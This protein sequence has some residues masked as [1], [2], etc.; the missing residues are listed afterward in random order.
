MGLTPVPPHKQGQAIS[1]TEQRLR[2]VRAAM[3]GEERFELSRVDL[4]RPGPHYA[5]DSVGLLQEQIPE[6][7]LIYLMGGDLLR[8]LPMWY[9]PQELIRQISGLGVMHRPG[10]NIDPEK[11][12]GQLPGIAKKVCFFN[13]PLLDISSSDIRLRI[14]QGRSFRYFL[15]V[16]VFDLILQN[17]YYQ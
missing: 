7:E 4:D 17:R 5:V 12:E 15:S 6:A 3:A 14:A 11:L 10:A 1:P 2:L 13:S 8:D 16:P 9:K